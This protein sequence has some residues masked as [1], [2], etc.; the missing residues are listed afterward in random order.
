MKYS[1][2]LIILLILFS[3][4]KTINVIKIFDN[5]YKII[6]Y[7]ENIYE[8]EIQKLLEIKITNSDIINRINNTINPKI[9][10]KINGKYYYLKGHPYYKSDRATNCDYFFSID[11]NKRIFDFQ[12]NIIELIGFVKIK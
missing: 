10:L 3:S 4:C 11:E 9:N 12:N 7:N 2:F 5:D 8:N 6:S 1:H